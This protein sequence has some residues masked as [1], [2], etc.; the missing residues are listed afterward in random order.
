MKSKESLHVDCWPSQNSLLN[1]A[2]A[3]LLDSER[4][5]V[6][7]DEKNN[8][9]M[10]ASIK[11]PPPA[12]RWGFGLDQVPSHSPAVGTGMNRGPALQFC[13]L[14]STELREALSNSWESDSQTTF[15]VPR[16]M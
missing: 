3:A 2:S 9:E 13:A 1:S 6:D 8:G 15:N 10:G 4:H 11:K 5:A 14:A 12:P 7:K 16:C